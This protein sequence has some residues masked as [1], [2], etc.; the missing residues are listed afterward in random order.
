METSR[1]KRV[2]TINVIGPTTSDTPMIGCS[3]VRIQERP[4]VMLQTGE[5]A[6]RQPSSLERWVG[7][8]QRWLERASGRLEGPRGGLARPRGRLVPYSGPHQDCCCIKATESDPFNASSTEF[9]PHI[10]LHFWL[11]L[12]RWPKVP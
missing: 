4:I 1:G 6:L 12:V 3:G 7:A 2:L 11:S 10:R 5:T 8:T 9:W